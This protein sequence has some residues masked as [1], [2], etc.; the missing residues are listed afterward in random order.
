MLMLPR[1]LAVL[2]L[3]WSAASFF[4]CAISLDDGRLFGQAAAVA[5]QPSVLSAAVRTATSLR[6]S[7]R[8]KPATGGDD[9]AVGGLPLLTARRFGFLP[10]RGLR[11]ANK[12]PSVRKFDARA[13]PARAAA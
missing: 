7:H 12:A 1:F 4:L 13:P 2:M 11:T 8:P 10:A 3:H 6:L 9:V 5:Q